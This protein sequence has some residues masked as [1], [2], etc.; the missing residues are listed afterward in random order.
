LQRERGQVHTTQA[1][2]AAREDTVTSP[3]QRNPLARPGKR[4]EALV[5]HP[6]LG[7]AAAAA[8]TSRRHHHLSNA[9][10][11]PLILAARRHPPRSG[12]TARIWTERR[13]Q[14][15]QTPPPLLSPATSCRPTRSRRHGSGRPPPPPTPTP[16][17]PLRGPP[18]G[19]HAV[20]T[21]SARPSRRH[22]SQPRSGP[23]DPGSLA[24]D[25]GVD[26]GAV[27]PSSGLAV[28][29]PLHQGEGEEEPRSR[30]LCS[31]PALSAA[32]LAAVRRGEKGPG[33]K[34]RRR[35]R[36]PRLPWGGATERV[37]GATC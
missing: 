24:L 13:C 6:G 19:P 18:R 2:A 20:A 1:K 33:E 36:R 29:Q 30:H 23:P 3:L 12:R 28:P 9:P 7:S 37:V 25:P 14:H 31:R 32:T 15:H 4:V 26:A 34:G 27:L 21:A 17:L 5:S 35:F 10:P 8:T 16:T 11:P 22:A